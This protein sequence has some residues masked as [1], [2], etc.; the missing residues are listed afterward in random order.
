MGGERNTLRGFTR[1]GR[2][3]A[4]GVHVIGDARCQT[5]SL[6]AWGSRNALASA[7]ALVDVL[8]E[9][10]GDPE[11][12][13]LAF[14]ARMAAELAGRHAYA[15]ARDRALQ[16]FYRGEPEWAGADPEREAVLRTVV[17]AA[18]RDADVFRAVTRWDLQLDPAD[19]L[20]RNPALL[21]RTRA[22]PAAGPRPDGATPARAVLLGLI[23]AR[24]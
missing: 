4:L 8:G 23:A 2:P 20:E 7:V 1:D 19:A 11:A 16:R 15:V 18:E 9:H 12:Q 14:D 24:A 5:N 3:I 17:P 13:A 22:L 6:Y 21:D 10:P